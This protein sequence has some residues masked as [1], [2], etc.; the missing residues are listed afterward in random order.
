[1][2]YLFERLVAPGHP[3]SVDSLKEDIRAQIQRLVDSHRIAQHRR[4]LDIL[5]ISIP[6]T[7]E[8]GRNSL[9]AQQ[10]YADQVCRLIQRYEPRL[11][12]PQAEV[13]PPANE[14]EPLE[15]QILAELKIGE[16]A[17]EFRFVTEV[18]RT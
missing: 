4:T 3:V 18:V 9:S 12:N 7:T 1:M 6:A 13:I 17:E 8:L 14:A 16:F 11:S 2:R 15:L 5:S 10:E